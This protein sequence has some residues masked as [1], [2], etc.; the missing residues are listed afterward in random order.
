MSMSAADDLKFQEEIAS[1]KTTRW[2]SKSY[3]ILVIICLFQLFIQI[4]LVIW[5]ATQC[6]TILGIS[7]SGQLFLTDSMT[8]PIPG[9]VKL[10]S[11]Q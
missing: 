6:T 11:H 4:G 3:K 2:L 7:L 1:G 10:Y 9:V 5:I 8:C